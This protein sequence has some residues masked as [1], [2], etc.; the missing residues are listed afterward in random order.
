VCRIKKLKKRPRSERAV[1]P[2]RERE[3]ADLVNTEFET[4]KKIDGALIEVLFQH[5]LGEARE[6]RE[7]LSRLSLSGLKFQPSTSQIQA[8]SA[9]V[10]P[11]FSISREIN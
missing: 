7:S 8:Y 4:I 10:M 5:L 9:V 2:E 3:M 1:K 6:N 11:V